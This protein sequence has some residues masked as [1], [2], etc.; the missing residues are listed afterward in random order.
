MFTGR[1][2]KRFRPGMGQQDGAGLGV[3]GISAKCASGGILRER[4]Q[5]CMNRGGSQDR[6]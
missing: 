1:T 5:C 6:L 3:A 2:L 4:H